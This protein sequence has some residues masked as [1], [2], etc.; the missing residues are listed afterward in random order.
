VQRV[1]F[2]TGAVHRVCRAA[3]IGRHFELCHVG[4]PTELDRQPFMIYKNV[5]WAIGFFFTNA[6]T[7]PRRPAIGRCDGVI[8]K[9]IAHVRC[10]SHGLGRSCC[11]A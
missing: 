4:I 7:T 8:R 5:F 11:F 1:P 2:R 9:P 3:G 10:G 6:A